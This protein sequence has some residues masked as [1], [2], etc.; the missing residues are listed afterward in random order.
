VSFERWRRTL[1]QS[2]P[3]RARLHVIGM[4]GMR[5]AL[6]SGHSS[7]PLA[8]ACHFVPAPSV[9]EPLKGGGGFEAR[10]KSASLCVCVSGSGA[11][12]AERRAQSVLCAVTAMR[13]EVAACRG[14]YR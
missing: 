2:L 10:L 4:H 13:P 3:E 14:T 8:Q 1:W 5:S 11:S 9:D 12:L 7:T 6:R